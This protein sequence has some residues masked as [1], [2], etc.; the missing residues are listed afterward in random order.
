[1]FFLTLGR[2]LLT[3]FKKKGVDMLRI[4]LV[5]LT[6]SCVMLPNLS[7]SKNKEK[8]RESTIIYKIKENATPQ[9]LEKF[10]SL[11]NKNNVIA[12][13]SIKGVDINVVKLKNIKG[14]EKAYSKELMASGAVKFALPDASVPHDLTTPNDEFYGSQWHH[15]N[16]NSPVAWDVVVGRPDH[17]TVKVCVLDTGVDTDHPDLLGNLLEGYNTAKTYLNHMGIEISNPDYHTSNVEAVLGHGTGTAGT[18]GAVGNNIV[19]VSGVAWDIGIVPVK[20]NFDDVE[21]YAYYSAMIEGIVWCA[22]QGA[23]VANLSYGGADYIGISDAAQYLRD[24]GGLLFMSSG[25]DGSYNDAISYPDYPSFIAVGATDSTDALAGFSEYGS[26][27]DLV[28]PGVDIATTYLDGRYVYYSGTSFSSPIAAGVA[29]LIYSI[30]PDFTPSE[31]ESFMFS[32]AVDLG[33]AGE[34]DVFGHGLV[35]AGSAVLA[36]NNSSFNNP[37]VAIAL[38]ENA[39]GSAPLTVEFDGS[40]STDDGEVTSY[41]W[42]FG[43]GNTGNGMSITH[44]YSDVGDYNATLTV[45]DNRGADNTSDPILI[46][47][48]PS[49]YYLVAPTNLSASVDGNTVHLTWLDNSHQEEGFHLERAMKI[50]GKYKIW[51]ITDLGTDTTSFTDTVENTGSYRYRINSFY[52]NETSDYSNEASVTIE[53]ITLPPDPDP[54][55]DPSVLVAPSLNVSIGGKNVNLSWSDVC[56]D[57]ETCTYHIE[58]GDTKVRGVIDFAPLVD[59][60]GTTHSET[61]TKGTYYYKVYVSTSNAQ[62]DDSNIVSAR[63]K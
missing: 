46:Q 22:D 38:P 50:R 5:L 2:S 60:S 3:I 28:A 6:A 37:P 30:N 12:K 24:R 8:I 62:S 15:N 21:S 44:T 13:H 14:L 20:I 1:M 59:V 56:P 41:F 51:E 23:K 26:Y 11:V 61:V 40:G 36:A 25:N 10:N 33:S 32:T 34:D 49:E 58:K 45:T 4:L 42:D 29:A 48:N 52:G 54:P 43:D 63:I 7:Y 27:I 55:T 18:V 57:G 47:V 19:G 16:I 31:V 17:E 35:N 53:S 39:T 9:Q